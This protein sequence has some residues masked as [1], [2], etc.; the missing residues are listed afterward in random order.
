[1]AAARLTRFFSETNPITVFVPSDHALKPL[2]GNAL[3]E[4]GHTDTTALRRMLLFH[5]IHGKVTSEQLF[6]QQ[7]LTTFQTPKRIRVS[8]RGDEEASSLWYKIKKIRLR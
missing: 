8:T 6:D 5:V 7:T 1:M 4:A 2:H 3:S